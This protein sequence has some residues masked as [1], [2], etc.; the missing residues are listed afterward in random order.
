MADSG[1]GGG[2]SMSTSD[3]LKYGAI[4]LAIGGGIARYE[5][6]QNAMEARLENIEHVLEQRGDLLLRTTEVLEKLTE[7]VTAH[8][9]KNGVSSGA[10]SRRGR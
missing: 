10:S 8:T 1:N 5:T 9:G 3:F 4:L 2:L 7:K 6:R